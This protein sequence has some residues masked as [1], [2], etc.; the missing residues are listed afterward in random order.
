[1]HLNPHHSGKGDFMAKKIDKNNI[2]AS[3]KTNQIDDNGIVHLKDGMTLD[4][5][6]CR[7]I[8]PWDHKY[9]NVVMMFTLENMIN[10]L[11]ECPNC[12]STI[13][14]DRPILLMDN[15]QFVYP[16]KDCT[17]VWAPQ[18]FNMVKFRKELR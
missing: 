17:W 15:Q 8:P 7:L 12:D 16:C 1:M 2:D 9:V 3:V 11:T 13:P 18:S 10:P 6:Q 4:L 14:W 5:S